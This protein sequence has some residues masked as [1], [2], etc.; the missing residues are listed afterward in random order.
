MGVVDPDHTGLSMVTGGGG[1]QEVPGKWKLV[2]MGDETLLSC[3][4]VPSVWGEWGRGSLST[5]D[6][7]WG[8]G[9]RESDLGP[10][11]PLCS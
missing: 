4:R 10:H 8:A 5:C 11:S 3:E 2:G 9:F 6:Q 7:S 1:T